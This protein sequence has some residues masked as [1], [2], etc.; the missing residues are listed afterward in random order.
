[1]I[2][3]LSARLFVESDSTINLEKYSFQINPNRLAN[4]LPPIEE[5]SNPLKKEFQDFGAFRLGTF[6][7]RKILI[8]DSTTFHLDFKKPINADVILI[9]N[10]AVKN[11]EWFKEHFIAD[12]VLLGNSN[13]YRYVNKMNKQ[14]KSIGFNIH[15]IGNDG[16]FVLKIEE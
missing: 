10:N 2:E 9:E 13:S 6:L 3:G 8:I 1:M 12:H 7:N 5:T 16:A 4:R 11:P 15:S 14:A